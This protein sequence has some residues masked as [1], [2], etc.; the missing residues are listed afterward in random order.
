VLIPI[1][2]VVLSTPPGKRHAA[3]ATSQW[4][5]VSLA[6]LRGLGLR[7]GAIEGRLRSGRLRRV[8]H[9]V[10]AV[11]GAVLPRE[12]RWLAAVLACGNDAVLS[13]VSAAVH[14]GLL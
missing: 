8:H 11:G 2:L 5:V 3:L 6:Q 1:A 12:G 13:H 9:G 7:R 14:W 4:G 10:Y